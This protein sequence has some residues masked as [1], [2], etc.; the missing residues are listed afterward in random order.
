M[1][2][3]KA[4]R[5][6][7]KIEAEAARLREIVEKEDGLKYD[8]QKLYI[9]LTNG[10]PYIMVGNTNADYFRFHS[11]ETNISAQGWTSPQ[12]T[13]QECLDYHIKDGFDIHV[14]DNVREG[15]EFFLKHYKG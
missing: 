13:A 11:F 9:G 14:F 2:K 7:A 4:L 12:S 6:I 10:E 15:F 1:D 5:K 8:S 3:A